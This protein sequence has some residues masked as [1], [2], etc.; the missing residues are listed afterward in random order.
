MKKFYLLFVFAVLAS[1]AGMSAATKTATLDFTAQGYA[2]NTEVTSLTIEDV[3]ITFSKGGNSSNPPKYY[4]SGTA[5]RCYAKNSFKIVTTLGNITRMEFTFG[6]DDKNEITSNPTGFSETTWTGASES[7]E[8]TIGGT[9]GNRRLQK[10]VVTYEIADSEL[11]APE[12]TGVENGG[13]YYGSANV[14]ISYPD[15]ATSMTYTVTKDGVA[16]EPVTVTA[17]AELPIAEVGSYKIEATATD[18]TNTLAATPVEFTVKSTKVA[19][20]AEFLA[21]GATATDVRWEFTCPLTVTY[22]YKTKGHL[23]VKDANGG[24]LLIYGYDS[25]TY[26]QGDVIPAGVT[27]VYGLNGN[28]P[29]MSEVTNLGTATSTEEVTPAVK[30]AA[31]IAA[32]DLAQYVLL[33]NVSYSPTSE[34]ITDASG[35]IAVFNRF[36]ITLPTSETVTY[37]VTAIVSVYNGALQVYPI[38]FTEKQV[39]AYPTFNLENGV[40]YNDVQTLVIS[41]ATT[42]A[43]I[44]YLIVGD[45]TN[46]E[47][48][49]LE[50]V[51]IPFNEDETVMVEAYATKDGFIQSEKANLEFTIAKKCA[52]P[53]FSLKEGTY[54]TAQTV[55]I[56]GAEGSTISYFVNGADIVTAPSPVDVELPLVAGV[57]T[58]YNIVA[59][60]QKEGYAE[61]DQAEANYTIDPEAVINENFEL[62]TNAALLTEG[63]EVVIVGLKGTSAYAMS[64]VQKANNRDGV[65]VTIQDNV[66]TTLGE[67]VAIFTIG[68]PSATTVSFYSSNS[69]DSDETTALEGYLYAADS[70][71]NYMR[72]Q[73]ELDDNGKFEVTIDST[74][75]SATLKAQGT[76]TRNLMRFN[77]NNSPTPLFSCYASGMQTVYIYYKPSTSGVESVVDADGV[78]IVAV[79][80][81]VNVTADK[82][83]AVAVYTAAGQVVSMENVAEGTTT[84]SVPAGFYIVRA[85]NTAAKVIVK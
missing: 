55:T 50:T 15:L 41:T 64:N 77:A 52:A 70:D 67:N 5:I 85:G 61:S 29:Q 30:T 42:G 33:K 36:S 6:S 39:V 43:T 66:I 47:A 59:A 54:N 78:S 75:G 60:A 81:G 9:K 16:A 11:I 35:E 21:N 34:S 8:F 76:N 51:E 73:T 7:V 12:I 20:I 57:S 80:G 74:D 48:T 71:K 53:T 14:S 69:L 82:A 4:K 38:E 72:T 28:S 23:Y 1:L 56:T 45:K 58:T 63:T 25:P 13:E 65:E 37:D 83:T 17:A 31:E 84:V 62:V 22:Q 79:A 18:G 19:N 27:G 44:H 40:T 24:A 2:N 46:I 68:R 10:I 26:A 32:T 3:T 49:A